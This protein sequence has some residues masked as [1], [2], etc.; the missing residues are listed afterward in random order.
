MPELITTCVGIV[1]LIALGINLLYV[2]GQDEKNIQIQ[3]DESQRLLDKKKEKYCT[4][5]GHRVG[6]S[7]CKM[8]DADTGEVAL[9]EYSYESCCG[10]TS[11]N[12]PN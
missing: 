4:T 10:A 5:Y 2:T 9:I 11:D 1:L 6:V 3:R 8:Y 7:E 12:E